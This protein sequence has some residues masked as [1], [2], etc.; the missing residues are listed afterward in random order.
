MGCKFGETL[1]KLKARHMMRSLP[2]QGA[3]SMVSVVSATGGQTAGAGGTDSPQPTSSAFADDD[4]TTYVYTDRLAADCRF[5]LAV[6][7]RLYRT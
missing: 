2:L 4:F 7:R 6:R 5:V 3:A 1:V